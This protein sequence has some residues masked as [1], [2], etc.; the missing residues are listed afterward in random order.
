LEGVAYACCDGLDALRSADSEP[1]DLSLIGG[2][3][4]SAYWRQLL[5]DALGV[6]FSYRT[7]SEVGPA[8]GA[9]RLAMI[10]AAAEDVEAAIRRVCPQPPEQD[11]HTPR[12]ERSDYHG[13]KL[14]RYRQLYQLTQPLQARPK[15]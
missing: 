3:A 5:A 8:L 4:R 15:F 10:S 13:A 1:R 2:G 14:A 6:P 11:R 7:G 12:P 9:A